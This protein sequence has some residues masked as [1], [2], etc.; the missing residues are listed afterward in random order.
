VQTVILN[1]NHSRNVGVVNPEENG[2]WSM[3]N[4]GSTICEMVL[5]KRGGT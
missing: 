2:T 1:G 4:K 3:K 5:D